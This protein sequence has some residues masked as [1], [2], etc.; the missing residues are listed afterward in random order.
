MYI[1][2]YTRVDLPLYSDSAMWIKSQ[3]DQIAEWTWSTSF[4]SKVDLMSDVDLRIK[5]ICRRGWAKWI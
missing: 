4:V 2:I 1:Y 5:W 3:M